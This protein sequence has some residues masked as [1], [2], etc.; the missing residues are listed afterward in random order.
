MKGEQ[1]LTM[2]QRFLQE[3]NGILSY[4]AL[5]PQSLK[6]TEKQ[7]LWGYGAA[8]H[9]RETLGKNCLKRSV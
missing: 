7:L 2:E 6:S 9:Y 1:S 5:S 4:T 8:F 3:A